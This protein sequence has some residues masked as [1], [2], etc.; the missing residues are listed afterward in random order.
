VELQVNLERRAALY[1]AI[2]RGEL[3]LP[4]ALRQLRRS[5]GKTQ[6]EYAALVGLSPRI[7]KAI[8]QGRG[9]P[10]LKSIRK[11]LKPFNLDLTVRCK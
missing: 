6:T 3:S 4:Q 8:E 10:T 2:V 1:E 11:V 9:N 5:V 7:L